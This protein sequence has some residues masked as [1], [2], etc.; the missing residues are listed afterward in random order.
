MR[1]RKPADIV[2]A[3]IFLLSAASA[4]GQIMDATQAAPDQPVH[5][6]VHAGDVQ[7]EPIPPNIFGSFSGTHWPLHLWRIRTPAS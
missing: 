3:S 7:K 6:R 5:L 1:R 4:V 2:V